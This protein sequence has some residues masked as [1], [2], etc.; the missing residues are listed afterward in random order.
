MRI[1][2]PLLAASLILLCAPQALAWGPLGHRVV[3]RLAEA[4]LTPS[5]RAE[6]DLPPKMVAELKALGLL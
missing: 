2:R 6:A 5:A 4:Q 1:V 3:A